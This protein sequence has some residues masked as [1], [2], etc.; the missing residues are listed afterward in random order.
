MTLDMY[1]QASERYDVGRV[2]QADV[3]NEGVVRHVPRVA[4]A[5]LLRRGVT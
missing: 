3:E 4:R 1:M 2:G 5:L